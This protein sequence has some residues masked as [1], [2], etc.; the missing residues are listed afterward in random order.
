MYEIFDD[1]GSGP[2]VPRIYIQNKKR[3]RD[4]GAMEGSHQAKKRKTQETTPVKKGSTPNTSN[5]EQP[6]VTSQQKKGKQVTLPTVA[7]NKTK[8]VVREEHKDSPKEA[9]T[10][11]HEPVVKVTASTEVTRLKRRKKE[12]KLNMVIE[13]EPVPEPVV[14]ELQSPTQKSLKT[15]AKKTKTKVLPVVNSTPTV[16]PVDTP[17]PVEDVIESPTTAKKTKKAKKTQVKPKIDVKAESESEESSVEEPSNPVQESGSKAE[18]ISESDQE[19][20]DEENSGNDSQPTADNNGDDSDEKSDEGSD[21]SDE[22]SEED[23]QQVLSL[24]TKKDIMKTPSTVDS[25]P[26]S[27]DFPGFKNRTKDMFSTPPPAF[28]KQDKKPKTVRT[29]PLKKKRGVT[30]E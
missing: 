16:K 4:G 30:K 8:E 18:V 27:S 6:T 20:S 22:E 2:F 14:E 3:D 28:Q 1:W 24:L 10:K 12:K 5:K 13:S 25:T 17:Q 15:K 11:P 9:P 7:N 21:E 26:R 19:G 29:D 23:L